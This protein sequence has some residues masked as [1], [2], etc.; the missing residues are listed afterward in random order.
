MALIANRSSLLGSIGDAGLLGRRRVRSRQGA[1]AASADD[2]MREPEQFDS[3]PGLLRARQPEL[4][5]ELSRRV[6]GLYDYE[7]GGRER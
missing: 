2:S 5:G 6:D 3:L 4:Y 1:M 7:A